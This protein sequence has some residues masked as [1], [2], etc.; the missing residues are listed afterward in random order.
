[1]LLLPIRFGLP[2]RGTSGVTAPTTTSSTWRRSPYFP[3][4][5]ASRLRRRGGYR[6]VVNWIE[7]WTQEY[8][9]RYAGPA[10]GTRMAR[11]EGVHL[12]SA[13]RRLHLPDVRRAPRGRGLPRNPGCSPRAVCRPHR[14]DA[15]G[16]W[17]SSGS[18]VYAGRHVREKR[19]DL[20]VR[21]SGARARAASRPSARARR[22]R[23]GAANDR[24]VSRGGRTST[25]GP[26]A[27]KATGGRENDE[28]MARAAC[29][30]T[31]SEREGYGSSS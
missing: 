22:R 26:D 3:L 13:R 1:M 27:R 17:S 14:A 31:A 8:W 6:L 29:L 21:A 5:A 24:T 16:A 2:S 9:P 20:L 15:R 23:A 7:V 19:V 25:A 10:I 28:A 12:T 11:A 4:L 18:S 30:A